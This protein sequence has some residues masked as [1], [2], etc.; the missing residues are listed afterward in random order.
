MSNIK[1]LYSIVAVPGIDA[2]PGCQIFAMV[3]HPT[4]ALAA[5]TFFDAEDTP[6]AKRFESWRDTASRL[7]LPVD[8]A[9]R[10][11]ETFRLRSVRS[12]ID[13][14]L[15]G[16]SMARESQVTGTEHPIADSTDVIRSSHAVSDKRIAEF[17]QVGAHRARYDA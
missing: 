10:S 16:K 11:F 13:C 7:L 1:K 2:A 5:P 15:I 6:L 8:V 17:A 12:S 14:I 9:T 3:L 4:G